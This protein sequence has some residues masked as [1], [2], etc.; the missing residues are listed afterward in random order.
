MSSGPRTAPFLLVFDGDPDGRFVLDMLSDVDCELYVTSSPVPDWMGSYVPAERV[1]ELDG[2]D[3]DLLVD[4]VGL[5]CERL[6]VDFA[7]VGTV[8]E[9]LLLPASELAAA[10]G[11][12]GLAPGTARR[13]SLNKLLM[14]RAC[15]RAG[16]ERPRFAA[17]GALQAS[18]LRDA[19]ERVGL[20][21]V[22]KPLGG[23][24]SIGVRKVG[25]AADV[26]EVLASEAGVAEAEAGQRLRPT[27]GWLVEEYIEGKL[28]S[29]DGIVQDGTVHTARALC[30][31]LLGPEPLFIEEGVRVPARVSDAERDA[32][33]DYTERVIAALGMD[34]C[35]F[36][37]ELRLGP[38]G[39]ALVEIAGRMP[40]Q[41]LVYEAALGLNFGHAL[42]EMWLGRAVAVPDEVRAHV[43]AGSVFAPRSGTLT[44][45]DGVEDA[46]RLDGI[47]WSSAAA[48]VGQPVTAYPQEPTPLA[49]YAG[50]A[51]TEAAADAL[52]LAAEQSIHIDIDPTPEKP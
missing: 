1:L 5:W 32:C 16:L 28:L 41:A 10:L 35:A 44:R 6:G 19:L 22:L 13:T 12:R 46:G 52:A 14:R 50:A 15:R 21:A 3:P 38:E 24:S 26:D 49:V 40:G 36:H 33:V 37:C 31:F 43:V 29:V 23:V 47:W 20:P 8:T 30:E 45:L 25:S 48:A 2:H 51:P 42:A 27:Q 11:V 18:A 9:D 4:A 17:I 34:D 7:G 39:P